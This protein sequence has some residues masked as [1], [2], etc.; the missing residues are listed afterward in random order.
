MV[1]NLRLLSQNFYKDRLFLKTTNKIQLIFLLRN[2]LLLLLLYKNQSWLAFIN[3][4]PSLKW[5]EIEM[6]D[7]E[8]YLFISLAV[9]Q[10]RTLIEQFFWRFNLVYSFKYWLFRI[11][12][13]QLNS[14]NDSS[15]SKTFFSW[16]AHRSYC[17]PRLVANI[18]LKKKVFLNTLLLFLRLLV[19]TWTYWNPHFLV[20]IN[21]FS[22]PHVFRILPFYNAKFFKL[23]QL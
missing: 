7:A 3:R 16:P 19:G 23:Y 1:Y 22:A 2:H 9:L 13:T 14:E 6:E 20:R 12:S 21:F 4:M 18:S 10:K 15:V 17:L 5:T 11:L 8:T